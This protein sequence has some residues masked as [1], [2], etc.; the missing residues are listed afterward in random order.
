MACGSRRQKRR[1]GGQAIG[2]FRKLW[3]AAGLVVITGDTAVQLV[4]LMR[5]ATRSR[6]RRRATSTRDF[7]NQQHAPPEPPPADMIHVYVAGDADVR[8]LGRPPP[9]AGYGAVA[10]T[11]GT[12]V[13]ELAG[14]IVARHTPNVR[15][16]T[17]N[18]SDLVSF[19]RAVRW[20]AQHFTARD[21]PICVRY[22]SEYAARIATG[23][24]KAKKHKAMAEEARQAWAQLKRTSGGRAWMRHVPTQDATYM[25]ARRL[26]K[27]GKG[28]AS[29][30]AETVN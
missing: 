30:Y 16:T 21:K 3:E 10:A 24:W 14:Q 23:A 25:A 9:P 5:A 18:L 20:A 28:G 13:F 11:G 29:I 8:K 1:D 22:N 26:A 6:W 27:A 17:Q 7:R 4:L 2:R 19:A 15:T 12:R